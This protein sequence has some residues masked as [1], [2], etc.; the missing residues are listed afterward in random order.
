MP[1]LVGPSVRK[2]GKKKNSNGEPPWGHAL[3]MVQTLSQC[4]AK[5]HWFLCAI[6]FFIDVRSDGKGEK[7]VWR[8]S[9]FVVFCAK[10]WLT[11]E[12]HTVGWWGYNGPGWAGYFFKYFSNDVQSRCNWELGPFDSWITHP[13]QKGV[14]FP[15][16]ARIK[17]VI[18]YL[19]LIEWRINCLL[20]FLFSLFQSSWLWVRVV[21]WRQ[22]L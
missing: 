13:W 20:I 2:V 17:Q 22:Y 1:F 21:I 4:C 14:L 15:G 9:L 16:H 7:L 12:N 8:V 10:F 18:Y 5:A 11:I 19:T 6:Y 3:W